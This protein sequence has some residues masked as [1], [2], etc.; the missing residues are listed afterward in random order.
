MY[1][2]KTEKWNIMSTSFL[3]SARSVDR[4]EGAAVTMVLDLADFA[5]DVALSTII[6][7]SV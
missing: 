7:C 1:Y 5:A 6:T 2:K 4:N 3:F